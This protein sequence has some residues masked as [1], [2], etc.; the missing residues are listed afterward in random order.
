M[1]SPVQRIGLVLLGRS[2]LAID[3]SAQRWDIGPMVCAL[4]ELGQL[5]ARGE[6]PLYTSAATAAVSPRPRSGRGRRPKVG[7]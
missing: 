7:G 3:V 6:D 2:E 4:A 5:G 1:G